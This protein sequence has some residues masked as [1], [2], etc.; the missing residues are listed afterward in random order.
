MIFLSMYWD[1]LNEPLRVECDRNK[2]E[3]FELPLVDLIGLA[4]IFYL[5][6]L[7]TFRLIPVTLY[8]KI[9]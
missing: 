3:H 6:L 1:L 4:H 8:T 2:T 9:T 5:H 7:K